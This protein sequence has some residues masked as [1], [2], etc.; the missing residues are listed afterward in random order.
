MLLLLQ[1]DRTGGPRRAQD[2]ISGKLGLGI[3]NSG[4]APPKK[5]I[6]M[7]GLPN[8]IKASLANPALVCSFIIKLTNA[9]RGFFMLLQQI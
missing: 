7:L 4:G 9:E 2:Q 3:S 5:N 1:E 6:P 8:T